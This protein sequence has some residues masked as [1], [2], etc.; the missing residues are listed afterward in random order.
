MFMRP[1]YG[2]YLE[3]FCI[4]PHF[5]IILMLSW[6]R[7]SPILEQFHMNEGYLGHIFETILYQTK[8]LDHFDVVEGI[9]PNF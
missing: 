7:F 4:K 1:N 6:V 8:L 2:A 5:E 9:K 3:P